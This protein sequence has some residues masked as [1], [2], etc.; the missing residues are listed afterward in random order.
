MSTSRKTAL[1]PDWHK[2]TC[3]DRVVPRGMDG[4]VD[5]GH[6]ASRR[7]ARSLTCGAP[8]AD[9]DPTTINVARMAL[10]SAKEWPNRKTVR[11]RFLDGSATQKAKVIA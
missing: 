3:I 4:D 1:S 2:H 10:I 8:L 9:L 6:E 11:C 5:A 7:V